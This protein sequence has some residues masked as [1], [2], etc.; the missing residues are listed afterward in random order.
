MLAVTEIDRNIL[1][2]CL[3]QKPH[4]WEDFVDRFIE[5]IV[6]VIN[7]TALSHSVRLTASDIDDLTAEVFHTFNDDNFAVLRHFRR[8]S[9]LATY[10]T[11]IARRVVVGAKVFEQPE[12]KR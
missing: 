1:D 7:Q 3:A 6:H 8:D 4:A 5:L 2:R 10:L 9:S 12:R 11:V